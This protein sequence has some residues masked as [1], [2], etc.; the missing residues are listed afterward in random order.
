MAEVLWSE[1]QNERVL[2]GLN[3]CLNREKCRL[4]PAECSISATARLIFT[5]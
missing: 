2:V 1:C 3:L 5:N 4:A